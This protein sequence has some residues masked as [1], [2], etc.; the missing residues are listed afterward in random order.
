M[1]MSPL[2]FAAFIGFVEL[3]AFPFI[4]ISA[5]NYLASV[6]GADFAIPHHAFTYLSF[7]ALRLWSVW[8]PGAEEDED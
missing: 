4:G 8:A 3:I 5:V 1:R 6:G 2:M 7:T